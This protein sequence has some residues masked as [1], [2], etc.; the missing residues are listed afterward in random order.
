MKCLILALLIVSS[1]AMAHSQIASIALLD[2]SKK[3]TTDGGM[4]WTMLRPVV[5]VVQF[6]FMDGRSKYSG[7][8]GLHW[9]HD[10]SPYIE[11][12]AK[13][14]A[15]GGP[16]SSVPSIEVHDNVLVVHGDPHARYTVFVF[17]ELGSSQRVVCSG[18]AQVEL[19]PRG[20][21]LLITVLGVT[22]ITIKVVR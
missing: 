10:A 18:N 11:P 8:G 7:D 22:P 19:L 14:I 16:T 15:V 17:D 13:A 20:H 4:T 3:T 12:Q 6:K 5:Q 9:T 21:R 1:A 2:G